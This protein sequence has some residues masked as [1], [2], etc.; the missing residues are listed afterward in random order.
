MRFL[1]NHKA[2]VFGEVVDKAAEEL[3]SQLLPG[4]SGS[5]EAQAEPLIMSDF[6]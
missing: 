4:G 1:A 3:P 6:N 2:Q 5:F